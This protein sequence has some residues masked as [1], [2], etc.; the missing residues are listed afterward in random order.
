MQAFEIQ[1]MTCGSCAGRITRAIKDLDPQARLEVDVKQRTVR[2]DTTED[3]PS[4]VAA[5]TEAGY[6]PSPSAH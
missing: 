2:I 1:S 4:L 3:R 6:P 5:L